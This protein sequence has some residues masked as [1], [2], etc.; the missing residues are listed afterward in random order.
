MKSP[1]I[2]TGIDSF[3]F[4]PPFVQPERGI[5]SRG[6]DQRIITEGPCNLDK[7]GVA[8]LSFERSPRIS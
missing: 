7:S 6:D 8:D 3:R 5:S 1:T 4:T 2:L